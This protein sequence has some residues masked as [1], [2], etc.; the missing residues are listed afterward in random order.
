MRINML[1]IFAAWFIGMFITI[2]T[3]QGVV[4]ITIMAFILI[5]IH[6]FDDSIPINP[7]HIEYGGKRFKTLTQLIKYVQN[8]G[9]KK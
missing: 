8:D 6:F 1:A 7:T 4:A 9:G 3:M 2:N 5:S